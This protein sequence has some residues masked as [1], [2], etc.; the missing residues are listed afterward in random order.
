MLDGQQARILHLS[1]SAFVR[2]VTRLADHE[3]EHITEEK[4]KLI[5][6]FETEEGGY[7]YSK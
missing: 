1:I 5:H 3:Q 7:F 2:A 4:Q 6:R